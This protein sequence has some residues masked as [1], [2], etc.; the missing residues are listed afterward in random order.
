MQIFAFGINHQTA[1]LDVRERVVFAAEHMGDAL[2]DLVGRQ[3]VQEAAIVSTCN[4]TEVYCHTEEPRP[5]IQWLADYHRLKP[6]NVEPYLYKLPH[7]QAVKHAFR[8][9]SG[10]DSMVLGEPQI[11]GQFK[12]AV[13]AAES[14]GTLGV[15]LH[16]LFQ[17][18]FAVAKTVRTE[19]EIGTSTVS[20]AAAAVRLAESIYPSIE[21]QSVLFIGAGEMI[22]LTATHFAARRPKHLTF[23]NR[24]LER[25]QGLADRFM[26]RTIALNDLTP[27][28]PLHDIIV[29]CTASPLPII[30]KGMVESALRARKHRPLLVVDLAVPRDVE[31]E[32]AQMDDVFLYTVDDLGR[33]AREGIESRASAVTQAEAIID[34]QVI[35]FMHWL[36]NRAVVPTIRALR[37]DGERARRRAV[38]RALKHLA[39]GGSPAEVIEQLSH[40][41]T[42]KLLH[43]PTHALSHAGGDERDALKSLL[44][45]LYDLR[46]KE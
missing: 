19:T 15:L 29:T 13:R 28:L 23:A 21:T 30:G 8:V 10:L 1:P 41:L 6:A 16:K 43:A 20:M 2:R 42:N 34:T 22:D 3:A 44:A 25:A 7:D 40:T 24:T 39:N 4:R 9:A 46:E 31:A 14:A 36:D 45:R 17:R 35:D 27:Q 18:T 32:V 38:E 11:L 37:D 5:A 33:I 12:D 26:G